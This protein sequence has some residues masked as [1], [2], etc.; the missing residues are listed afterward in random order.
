MSATMPLVWSSLGCVGAFWLH[1]A[2]ECIGMERW[3]CAHFA[4]DVARRYR[5]RAFVLAAGLLAVSYT[6]LAAAYLAKWQIGF[7]FPFATGAIYAN[8]LLHV[9]GRFTA[10]MKDMPGYWS[11]LLLLLPS[12]IVWAWQAQANALMTWSNLSLCL[13]VGALL[14]A[15]LAAGAIL[16]AH[17]LTP[18]KRIRWPAPIGWSGFSLSA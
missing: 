12:N 4:P 13:F 5:T 10:R 3:T 11:A 14:Q 18:D 7:L 1:N 17:F 6:T 2:E 15:P 9:F 8:A 16:I